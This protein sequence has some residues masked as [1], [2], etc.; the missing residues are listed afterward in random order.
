MDTVTTISAGLAWGGLLSMLHFGGLW[1]CLMLMP[2]VARP[3]LWF[4][5]WLLVRYTVTLTGFWLALERGPSAAMGA[6]AG[7]YAMRM[8]LVS[9]ISRDRERA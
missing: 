2:K 6:C 1:I 4:Y 9:R 8:L 5:G 7:L 3:R